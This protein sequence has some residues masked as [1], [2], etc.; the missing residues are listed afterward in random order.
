MD[1]VKI[2]NVRQNNG[3][4]DYRGIDL[5]RIISGSQLYP[6]DENATYFYYDGTIK[7]GGDVSIIA[8][9]TYDEIK[10]RIDSAPKP[11][12]PEQLIAELEA[13]TDQAVME[14]TMII[15]MGGMK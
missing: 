15:A 13:K 2:S 9:A 5:D 6:T 8:Q 7:V 4:Y 12:T 14:L 3:T 1:I 11:L 10:W